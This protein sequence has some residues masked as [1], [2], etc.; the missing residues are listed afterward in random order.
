[1]ADG[2]TPSQERPLV[3][4]GA[5]GAAARACLRAG[6]WTW[7]W[8]RR[9]TAAFGRMLWRRRGFLVA[10]GVR[11]AWI[12][13]L[14]LFVDA[15]TELVQV[16]HQFDPMK[17]RGVFALGLGLCSLTVLLATHRRMRWAGV[18]L[19]TAHGAVVLMLTAL[20]A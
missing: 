19:G 14:L 2:E 10:L 18:T 16:D 13:A 3:V 7:P 12:A 4:L 9:G 6:V 15:T 1:M 17:L 20:A 8:L 11:A 5:L